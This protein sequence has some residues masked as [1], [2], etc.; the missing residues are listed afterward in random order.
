MRKTSSAA[1][2]A[3]L[4]WVTCVKMALVAGIF[5]WLTLGYFLGVVAQGIELACQG[6]HGGQ[7]VIAVAFLSHEL[8]SD[9]GSAQTRIQPG[10]TKLGVGL[11]LT[12]DDGFEVGQ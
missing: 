1:S 3:G 2:A 4:I 5:L 8:A 12:I 9:F 7:C 11:T 10:G 6:L